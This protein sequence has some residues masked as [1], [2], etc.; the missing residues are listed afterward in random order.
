MAGEGVWGAAAGVGAR[1]GVTDAGTVAVD[2]WA[3]LG[4]AAPAA[5]TRFEVA[6]SWQDWLIQYFNL[7]VT[8]LTGQGYSQDRIAALVRRCGVRPPGGAPAGARVP[9]ILD[10]PALPR[11]RRAA[12]VAEGS[13]HDPACD[14]TVE[15]WAARVLSSPRTLRRDFLAGSGLTFERW[16]L[17]C[18]LRAAV[19]LLV[20]G[21]DVDQVTVRVGFASRSGL[22][23]AFRHELGVTP[24]H[25]PRRLAA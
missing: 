10:P 18:R 8:P 3:A 25:L 23:R 1:G 9:D 11:T 14:L 2:G 22:S 24:H 6:P 4:A 12:A 20:A 7:Q 5:A 21:Y 19:E 15:Q 13:M 16:R 17:H